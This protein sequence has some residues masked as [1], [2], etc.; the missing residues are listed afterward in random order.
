MTTGEPWRP[1]GDELFD[2]L[3]LEYE[4]W[5]QTPLGAFVIAEEERLL[6]AALPDA[7]GR[8]LDVGAGTGWWSRILARRGFQVMAVE[9]AAAMRRVGAART[10]EPIQWVSGRAEE[11]PLPAEAFDLVLLMTVLEFVAEPA[12]AMAEAWRSLRPGGTLL[13]GHL[14]ALS[15]WAALYRRLGDRGVAPWSGARFVESGAIGHWLGRPA[16]SRSSCV[17]L[18]PGASPPFE[19]ADQAGRLAGNAGALAVL[20]WRKPS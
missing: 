13:V 4:A 6:L 20:R 15:P 18:A 7:D 11:L 3:A 17:F 19:T 12:R 2:D 5:Y 8:L 10:S 1:V 16:D 14:D 9:P